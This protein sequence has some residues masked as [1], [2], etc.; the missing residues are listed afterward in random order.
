MIKAKKS[1][2]SF[3]FGLFFDKL[4]RLNPDCSVILE[5][6]RNNFSGISELISS[7]NILNKMI[8]RKSQ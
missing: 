6:Y 8:E 7:Y 5:L 4:N 2:K 1:P 3:D